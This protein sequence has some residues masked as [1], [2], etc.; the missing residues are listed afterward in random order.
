MLCL[1]FENCQ[2][3]SSFTVG[4]WSETCA[5]LSAWS[6]KKIDKVEGCMSAY[7]GL[8]FLRYP[9][10]VYNGDAHYTLGVWCS[11]CAI[12]LAS[13][14][15]VLHCVCVCVSFCVDPIRMF[16]Q[17][18]ETYLCGMFCIVDEE[19][20]CWHLLFLRRRNVQQSQMAPW[21]NVCLRDKT[22]RPLLTPFESLIWG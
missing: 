7:L 11:P 3:T 12:L 19:G 16:A 6:N 13:K 22:P 15:C 4:L 1:I 8:L 9:G 2:L 18:E 17:S 21:L 14:V 10:T 20:K 5:C